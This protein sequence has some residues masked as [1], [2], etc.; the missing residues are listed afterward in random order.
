MEWGWSVAGLSGGVRAAVE[1]H[2]APLEGVEAAPGVR[3]LS[4]EA[5][6]K[7]PLVEAELFCQLEDSGPC[8]RLADGGD[9]Q[10]LRRSV[11]V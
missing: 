11:P 5:V 3:G 8:S 6:V 2:T 1:S 10:R 4:P 9:P 7:H